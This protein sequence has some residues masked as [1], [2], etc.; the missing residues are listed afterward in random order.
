MAVPDAPKQ[1]MSVYTRPEGAA[2]TR[3]VL[4]TYQEGHAVESVECSWYAL[5]E[6]DFA[7]LE[8]MT[9]P[10]VT[11]DQVLTAVKKGDL[12]PFLESILAAAHGRKREKRGIYAPRGL[13]GDHEYHSGKAT[14]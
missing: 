12:D 14:S 10:R 9:R 1:C 8:E 3:A 13:H 6:A 11:V 4:C 5:C 2:E 7:W